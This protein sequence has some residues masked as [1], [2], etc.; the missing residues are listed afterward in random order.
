V[1]NKLDDTI[2]AFSVNTMT[3]ALTPLANSPFPSGGSEPAAIV[4]VRPQ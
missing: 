3:G 4:I 1:V 2:A